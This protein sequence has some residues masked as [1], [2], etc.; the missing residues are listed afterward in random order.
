MGC[1]GELPYKPECVFAVN[2]DHTLRAALPAL[3]SQWRYVGVLS[4]YIHNEKMDTDHATRLI[5]G[6]VNVRDIRNLYAWMRSR[7]GKVLD[8]KG[9]WNPKFHA[10]WV[11]E[12]PIEHYPRRDEV[13]SV[14]PE[15]LS[16]CISNGL[17]PTDIPLW[18]ISLTDDASIVQQLGLTESQQILWADLR[19]LHREVGL[20]RPSLYCYVLGYL[21]EG[22][23][24][25]KPLNEVLRLITDALFLNGL[26][27]SASKPLGLQDPLEYIANLLKMLA[28]IYTEILNRDDSFTAFKLTHP[29]ILSGM[30]P[31]GRWMTLYAY[32]GGWLQRPVVVKCG[33]SPLYLGKHLHCVSCG[34]LICDDCGFC[35]N[36]CPE[37]EIR[38]HNNHPSF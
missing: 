4:D 6:Q 11:F 28:S 2:P 16:Q 35:S 30:K 32:C 20:S 5:L 7:F 31:D 33:A 10:G 37:R 19:N 27:A 25:Q 36:A 24:A 23:A 1:S 34:H 9:M 13:L 22:L 21:L 3:Q 8:L 26:V 38:Q 12:Y 29:Q 15:T 14:I 18:V 17:G